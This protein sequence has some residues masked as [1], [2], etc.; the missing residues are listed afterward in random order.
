MNLLPNNPNRIQQPRKCCVNC[1][2]TYKTQTNLQKHLLLCEMLYKRSK[3]PREQEDIEIPSQRIIYQLLLEIGQKYN[4]LEEKVNEINK[5][6]VKKKKKIDVIEWLNANA[7]PQIF[8][9]NISEKILIT[10]EHIKFLLYNSF[11]DTLNEIFTTTIYISQEELN[12]DEIEN[13]I[14][15]FIQNSNILY[16]FDKNDGWIKLTN[17]KLE[18]FLQIIQMK[19]SKTF[20]E[21][22]KTHQKEIKED[23][24]LSSICNN[25]TG[26]LMAP[27]LKSE[28]ILGKIRNMMYNKMKTDIKAILEYEFEF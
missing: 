24:T 7:R 10:D 18:K 8:F 12:K 17:N 21:W 2:K 14:F 19:I 13:P 3:V 1:G 25:A 20:Y 4:R 28:S 9:E 15:A 11:N 26:K 23:E 22:K 16:I 5:Y 6:V 27:D